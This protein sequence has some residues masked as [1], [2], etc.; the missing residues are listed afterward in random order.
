MKFTKEAIRLL[1]SG[2]MNVL[3]YIAGALVA[4]FVLGLDATMIN[5]FILLGITGAMNYVACRWIIVRVIGWV[6]AFSKQR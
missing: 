1:I 4:E 3:V 2:T 5:V 6:D